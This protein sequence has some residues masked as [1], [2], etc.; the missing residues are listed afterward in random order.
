MRAQ[1]GC[2]ASAEGR[3]VGVMRKHGA[4][5]RGVKQ[6]EARADAGHGARR[7]IAPGLSKEARL[8]QGR[9]RD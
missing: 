6:K 7:S 9:D 2:L 3:E 1:G 5:S 4:C 8:F